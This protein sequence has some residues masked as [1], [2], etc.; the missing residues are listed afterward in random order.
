MVA[1][2]REQ[3]MVL[4]TLMAGV[5]MRMLLASEETVEAGFDLAEN[6]VHCDRI[7]GSPVVEFIALFSPL[8]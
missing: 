3:L 6:R 2:L 8:A 5:G 4:G 7:Y 1:I